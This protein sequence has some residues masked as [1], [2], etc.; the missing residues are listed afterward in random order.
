MRRWVPFLV[1]TLLAGCG[2]DGEPSA[3]STTTSTAAV[4]TTSPGSDATTSTSAPATGGTP[5]TVDVDGREPDEVEPPP[6]DGV[7]VTAV[8]ASGTTRTPLPGFGEVVVEVRR[9]DGEV[10]SWCLLLAETSAQIQRG[11][12]EVTD[13]GL[14]GYDGMLFRF[15]EARDGGFYM[16]NTPQ[17]LGIAYL[18][19]D[20][21][22]VSIA[23]MEPC[24]DVDGCPSYPADGRF[25]RAVEVPVEAGG[26][27]RLGI[28]PGAMVTDTG[29][30]C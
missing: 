25:R 28:A 22:V 23:R 15:A 9:Q 7:P 17:P 19:G 10:V 27:D 1:A 5:T 13:P 2:S 26:V 11:L 3:G 12:M 29:H 21:D 8:P 16:R 14:G 20:G 24:P 4:T 6:A 30:T 18:D